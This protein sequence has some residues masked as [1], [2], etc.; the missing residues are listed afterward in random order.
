[1]KLN[2]FHIVFR[3]VAYYRTATLYQFLI[4]LL[5]SAIITG[6]LL[7]GISVR[8][9]LLT[10]N[11]LQ[12]NGT[13][14]VIH[15]GSRYFP[16]SLVERLEKASGEKC[17]GI[18]ETKGWVRS[19]STGE[20]AL[21]IQV[22]GI[23]NQFFKF[24]NSPGI[25]SLDKGE[26]AIN[27][28]LADKLNLRIGDDIILRIG[29]ISDIPSRSPFAPESDD[30][31]SFVLTI[32]EIIAQDG[33][34]NFTLGLS[35]TRPLNIYLS[36]SEFNNYF[37]G[38]PKINR[39]LIKDN[40]ELTL[41]SIRDDLVNVFNTEDAGL[42][43]RHVETCNQQEI[44]SNRIFISESEVEEITAAIPEASPIITYLA[45]QI[46]LGTRSTPYSF[47]SALPYQLYDNLPDENG[48]VI[49]KWLA[50][51]LDAT[52]GD[53]I[54]LSYYIMGN[55]KNLVEKTHDFIISDITDQVSIWSDPKLMPEFPGI[56]GSESCSN[57]DAGIPIALDEIREKDEDYWD[58]FKGTPKAFIGYEKG[59]EL[60]GNNF[61]PATAIRFPDNIERDYILNKLNGHIDPLNIGF[62]IINASNNA[63]EAA[64]NSVDFSTLF[65]SLS[66]FIILSSLIL[67]I[68]I[69]S[70]HLS[71]RQDQ[72]STLRALGF[73]DK[74]ITRIFFLES[75]ST[76]FL[77][78]LA[79][80]FTGNLF[81]I[82]IIKSLNSVWRGAVQTDTLRS[83][84]DITSMLIGLAVTMI[85]VLLVLWMYLR[86]QLRKHRADHVSGK[87][88]FLE[89][90]M[91]LFFILPGIILII[92]IVFALLIPGTGTVLW[93]VTGVTL[94]AAIVLYYRL[95]ISLF[96]KR[97]PKK[98]G[99]LVNSFWPY[100]TYF[101]SRA[102]TPI[103]FLAAGIF[104]VVITGANR[105]SYNVDTISRESGT[106]GYLLWGE[107]VTPFAYDLNSP[108]GKKEYELPIT[109]ESGLYFIQAKRADGD[110]ASCLNLNSVESPPL[111][112]ID[113][114]HFSIRESFS[115]AT[116][117]KG[118]DVRN[119]WDALS[120]HPSRNTIYGIIDQTVLQW[121][122]K[123]KTGDTLILSTEN[124][125]LLNIILAAGLKSSIFQGHILIG[126]HNF[127]RFFP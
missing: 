32:K 41:E 56:S 121:N 50:N 105:K 44:I 89:N 5:L 123:R 73:S 4:I 2:H 58:N 1:L 61:G 107:T 26:V 119:P 120:L 53:S 40:K 62:R 114:S 99:S 81:N 108:E 91:K 69:V 117:M 27:K 31:E 94:F 106:G 115:F 70:S 112:G 68:L 127:N 24:N 97:N 101:P 52:I 92:Q 118:L 59:R 77:G 49:N 25:I 57:W 87:K 14:L 23:N 85:L 100:Y 20:T 109:N 126:H 60:W 84:F 39:I 111:L 80:A 66:F 67:L 35:H 82:L 15:S 43:L 88:N 33:P 48:I 113:A 38:N 125:E 78:S 122:L 75:G 47:V 8:K 13:G 29:K 102:I 19:F 83:F 71:T 103:L 74:L 124:G 45:N 98:S 55:Y 110:D 95:I 28:K 46:N 16:Q 65:L 17:E 18:L 22:F 37:A 21:N 116:F 12:L 30:F 96:R 63:I 42:S 76:A 90:N 10:S 93:F 3:S 51:D 64:E 36:L 34:A 54:R 104:I 11:Q 6:S 9:S 86:N 7:V 79:G 72:I